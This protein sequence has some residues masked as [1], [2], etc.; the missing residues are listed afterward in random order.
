MR[1]TRA[2]MSGQMHV[3]AANE[4]YGGQRDCEQSARGPTPHNTRAHPH[5]SGGTSSQGERI[6]S[7]GHTTQESKL[8]AAADAGA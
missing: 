6:A 5:A 2:E 3:H 1:R 4:V 8:T 7:L